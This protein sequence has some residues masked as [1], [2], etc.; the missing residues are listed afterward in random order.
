MISIFRD[1]Q[2]TKQ[3]NGLV[4][5]YRTSLPLR[6]KRHSFCM[7]YLLAQEDAHANPNEYR[8]HYHRLSAAWKYQNLGLELGQERLAVTV[9]LHFRHH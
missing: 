4:W 1:W 2:A 6:S 5:I 3:P 7:R 8:H 9:R